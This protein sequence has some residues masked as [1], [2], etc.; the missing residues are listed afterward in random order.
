[1]ILKIQ[2]LRQIKKWN[3][4][5]K[6]RRLLRNVVAYYK[7]NKNMKIHLRWPEKQL[8]KIEKMRN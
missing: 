7:K 4:D 1:M 3:L 5:N 8:R 6:S 2:Q